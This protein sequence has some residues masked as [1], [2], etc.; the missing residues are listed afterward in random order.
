MRDSICRLLVVAPL[1]C[2]GTAV[3]GQPSSRVPVLLDTDIG[4]DIDDAFALALALGSDE[5]AVRGITTAG[6][7]AR[8]KAMM[9]C[10][11]LSATGR[12]HTRVA[13]GAEPQPPRP[14]TDLEKYYYHPDVL[15]D[16]TTKPEKASAVAFLNERLKQHGGKVTLVALGPLT[17]LS[18]LIE[19]HPDSLV[20]LDRVI[21]MEA[22]LAADLEASRKVLAERLPVVVMAADAGKGLHLDD[23]GVAKVFGPG[24]PLTRQVQAMYQMWDRRNPPLGEAL[25]VAMCFEPRFAHIE[26]QSVAVDE[27]GQLQMSKTGT[28]IRVVTSVR[29]DEFKNW[30]ERRM[31]ALVSPGDRPSRVLELGAMPHRVHV[32]EDFDSDIERFWW[33]SGKPETERLPPGSRRACRGVLTHDFDDLLMR[34]RQMYTA[35]IFNPVPGPPMGKNT[36]LSFRY[37]LSGTDT[38]RVQIYS[39][40]NGYHRHLILN[41][42]PQQSWQQATVDMTEARR[43]DGTGGPLSEHERIDD[44][45][46][47]VDPDAEMIVDDIVLYDAAPAGEKVPF[48]KRIVFA[49][50]FDTGKQGQHWP[51]DFEIVADAGSFWKAV[52]SV[53][54]KATGNPWLRIGLR[55]QRRLGQKTAVSFRYRLRGTRDLQ[56]VLVNSETGKQQVAETTK[57]ETDPWAKTRIAFDTS[58]LPSIDEIRMLLP[59]DAELF[60][61]DLL[62]FEPGADLEE[63]IDESRR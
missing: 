52:R 32:A 45:Q 3:L 34:S 12:R 48:P 23:R 15:F 50:T 36:R 41:G 33:M 58:D 30:Y 26:M 43:S 18:R 62:L 7:D 13:A 16:R 24:T 6:H 17:N 47:Y 5:L 46:F 11:F 54:N 63:P 44:I 20:K 28:E 37:W 22:N 14:V 27:R 19:Q 61:D 21:L 56:V 8:K 31:A 10:R 59:E 51:G 49:G 55:G 25:A 38:I 57:L 39:L 1:L 35:V 9:V 53:V 42:L 4:A 40:T 29:T 60:V 2:G